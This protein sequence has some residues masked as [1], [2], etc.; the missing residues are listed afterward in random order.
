M[1]IVAAVICLLPLLG[2]CD[3]V[4]KPA[5]AL[6]GASVIFTDKT[7]GDHLISVGSG[8]DCSSVRTELGL[9]YCKEDEISLTPAVY[10]YRTLGSV[11]CYAKPDPYGL[12]QRKIGE[13]EHNYVRSAPPTR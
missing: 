5:T 4:W 1:R 13:N 10:C 12:N 6:D 7:L 3:S 8:K 9:T 11:D 2:G